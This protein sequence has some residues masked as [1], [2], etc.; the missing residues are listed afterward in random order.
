MRVLH[1]VND[2]S[3]GGVSVLLKEALPFMQ[4]AG[5]QPE[6]LVLNQLNR[7]YEEDIESINIPI[8]YTRAKSIFSPIHILKIRSKIQGFDLIH[9]HNFPT[10][11]WLAI[12]NRLNLNRLPIIA[13][14]HNTYNRRRDYKALRYIERLIY[15]QFDKIIA[16]SEP[17]KKNLID[18]V[19][20][21]SDKVMTINNGIPI[22]KYSDAIPYTK[23]E[24]IKTH[25]EGN[26][27]ILMVSRMSIEK[28]HETLI[29]AAQ[30]LPDHYHLVFVGEGE[31]QDNLITYSR[32]LKLSERI[33][34]LG[35]R[36]DVERIMKSVDVFVLSS[37]Y[38][39]F[40]LAAVEAMA[41]GLPVIAS[42][43]P[44]L[45]ENVKGAGI[46]FNNGDHTR[47]ANEILQLLTNVTK[48]KHISDLC[49]LRAKEFSIDKMVAEYVKLYHSLI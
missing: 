30:S 47:L 49:S 1:I 43:V 34:F 36:N 15:G 25:R 9:S 46:L 31:L 16:I 39:G 42:D 29:L 24:L 17:T 45:S 12:A 10:N 28:D 8:T 13:T 18:W 37:H 41:S 21:V 4:S 35:Y 22:Q 27:Y 40:G 7:Y 2:L 44:G 20:N 6:L 3:I 19:S 14:E 48:Y 11:Y 33:H 38:D 5:V 32:D 23:S 26:K